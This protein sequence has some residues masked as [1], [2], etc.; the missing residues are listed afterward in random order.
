M[1]NTSAPK[2]YQG[3]Q[4]SLQ[5]ILGSCLRQLR[6][7]QAFSQINV[8]EQAQLSIRNY[9]DIE[10]GVR[11]CRIDTVSKILEVYNLTIFNFF[12][13][14]LMEEFYKTGFEPLNQIL[15]EENFAIS[16]INT[17]GIFTYA[18]PNILNLIGYQ[19][20]EI[21]GKMYL[22]ETVKLPQ[23]KL[24]VEGVFKLIQLTR[25]HPFSWQGQLISKTGN[26]VTVKVYWRYNY[27]KESKLVGYDFAN[28]NPNLTN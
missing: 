6:E 10:Y 14:Y 5:K 3:E 9:Q 23:E 15:S 8:A 22:W 19:A 28:F 25:P 16:S 24:F 13:A 18:G 26:A 20:N 2:N 12:D 11:K 17:E 7:S 27:D 4:K 21:V 1:V